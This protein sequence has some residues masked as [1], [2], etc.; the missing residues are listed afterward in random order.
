MRS[1]VKLDDE[2]SAPFVFHEP[3]GSL[4]FRAFQDA[5]AAVERL[6]EIYARN[7]AF[8]RAAFREVLKGS[9]N[10]RERA[11]AYYPAIRIVVETYDPI[12]TR[13]S[14]GHVAEPGIYQTTITQPA[15]FRDYLIEQ[16]SQLLQNHRVAV[17]V[18]ESDSPIPLHFAFPEAPTS[19]A[20]TW[21][22]SSAP[23]ATCSTCPTW[24]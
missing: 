10:G 21:R 20:S 8:L 13:L 6:I 17:E 3:A 16:V 4:A 19:R 9:T 14:Y 11:R 23:C 1:G 5:V 24:R 7:T 15:L 22:R 18:G 2:R 12:D